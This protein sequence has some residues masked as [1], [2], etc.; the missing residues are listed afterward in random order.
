ME[1]RAYSNQEAHGSETN[2]RVPG[3]T[4]RA[5]AFDKPTGACDSMAVVVPARHQGRATRRAATR[6]PTRARFS[7][8]E[9]ARAAAL[10]RPD[11]WAGDRLP[12]TTTGATRDHHTMPRTAGSAS[13]KKT[14]SHSR[15][16][17]LVRLERRAR[18]TATPIPL[19]K[20]AAPP[21]DRT[22]TGAHSVTLFRI[23]GFVVN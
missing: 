19:R 20:N 2:R 10:S 22:V 17:Q 23:I 7:A 13:R 5:V 1:G 3:A 14:V 12:A 8:G 4:K 15:S 9:P 11:G 16:A 21:K 6:T 18:R